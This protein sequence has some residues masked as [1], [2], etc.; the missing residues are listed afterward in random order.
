MRI[1][2]HFKISLLSSARDHVLGVN[3]KFNRNNGMF[4]GILCA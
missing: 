3:N 4:E 2:G 1:Q